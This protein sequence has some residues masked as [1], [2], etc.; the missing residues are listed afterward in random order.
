MSHRIARIALFVILTVSAT[1]PL[2]REAHA[3]FNV[4]QL[5]LDQDTKRVKAAE[6]A[7]ANDDYTA[8]RQKASTTLR[9]TKDWW[10]DNASFADRKD[11]VT[12][13]PI[14]RRALRV[15]CLATVRDSRSTAADR[16]FAT[17]NLI[18]LMK[19]D[20]DTTLAIDTAEAMATSPEKE[21][22]ALM[23]LRVQADKDLIGS[24]HAYAALT[25]LERAHGNEAAAV[26]AHERCVRMAKHARTCE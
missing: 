2:Q 24:A 13:A 19:H 1:V 22:L 26:T 23:M 8:A 18:A 20:P 7:L 4:T 14:G 21:A 15:Y 10:S 11:L 16:G 12:W 9:A 17:K 5:E 25:R 6:D 3:C